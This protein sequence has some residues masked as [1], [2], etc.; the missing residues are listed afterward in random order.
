MAN[1]KVHVFWSGDKAKTAAQSYCQNNNYVMLEM[2]HVAMYKEKVL[3]KEHERLEKQGWSRQAIWYQNELP[4]WEKLSRDFAL[5]S[6]HDEV[7]VFV[8]VSYKEP[9]EMRG[10]EYRKK[11]WLNDFYHGWTEEDFYKFRQ[12]FPNEEIPKYL[13]ERGYDYRKSVLHRVEH[14][15][16]K[17]MHKNLIIH[18]VK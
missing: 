8:D 7:H 18:Y 3:R 5:F 15:I 10:K 17:R 11:P 12:M 4:Q 16:L 1:K 13:K 9:E 6:P 2:T 14:P